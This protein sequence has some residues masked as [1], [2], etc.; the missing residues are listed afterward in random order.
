MGVGVIGVD[1]AAGAPVA[2]GGQNP[3]T[4]R[5]ADIDGTVRPRNAV[6]VAAAPFAE[7]ASEG[8]GGQKADGDQDTS[9]VHFV[10]DLEVE[11]GILLFEM[12]NES[13]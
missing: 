5:V 10:I 8:G 6:L 9:E 1:L 11:P 13:Q 4:G 2:L 3:V 12:W 7:V